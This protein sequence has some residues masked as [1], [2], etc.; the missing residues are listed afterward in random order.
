M[1][2]N[3]L[4]EF[5]N[6]FLNCKPVHISITYK[7]I[8]KDSYPQTNLKRFRIFEMMLWQLLFWPLFDPKSN[9]LVKHF[10]ILS[11]RASFRFFLPF[12]MCTVT[13]LQ[14]AVAVACNSSSILL[15]ILLIHPVACNSSSELA[16]FCPVHLVHCMMGIFFLQFQH[17]VCSLMSAPCNLEIILS[18]CLPFIFICDCSFLFH[19]FFTD[20]DSLPDLSN[21]NDRSILFVSHCRRRATWQY[22]SRPAAPSIYMHLR[23][24]PAIAHLIPFFAIFWPSLSSGEEAATNNSYY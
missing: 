16:V 3:A 12:E 5:S 13:K 9:F 18:P 24:L 1:K 17:F 8:C 22:F 6:G 15:L 20:S 2:I 19:L 7:G 21:S 10:Q 11:V 4:P 14:L 23:F